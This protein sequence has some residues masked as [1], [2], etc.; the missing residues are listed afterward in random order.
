MFL[1]TAFSGRLE[2]GD[3]AD[4]LAS[5]NARYYWRWH[6]RATFFALVSG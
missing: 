1:D 6:P 5:A 2:S 3:I 4:G